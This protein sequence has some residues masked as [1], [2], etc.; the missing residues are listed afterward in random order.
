M[1]SS[2]PSTTSA[3]TSKT[4]AATTIDRSGD[5]RPNA[6]RSAPPGRHDPDFTVI[7]ES[8]DLIV[9]DKPAPLLVHPSVPGNPPTLL[10]GLQ[11]LLAYEIANGATLSII[12]RLDRETSGVVL[13]AKNKATARR[14]GLAM[15][16]RQVAKEYVALVHGHPPQDR[17]HVDSPILRAG[18]IGESEV[19]VKQIPHPDGAPSHTGFEVLRRAGPLPGDP[20]GRPTSLV[21]CRPQT[22]RMHQIRVHLKHAGLP[23]VGDKIYG[24]DEGCYLEFIETGWNDRLARV[25]LLP[26]QALHCA[27]MA[28][29]GFGEWHAPLPAA[30]AAPGASA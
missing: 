23:I 21:R 2:T 3:T 20:L 14:L 5:G 24:P 25:L 16:R 17:F 6:G 19:W 27:R 26:R 4:K 12:N 10:D 30:L 22:G 15:Q 11:G 8:D 18:E 29:P 7:D 13:V 9:V 1:S 28:I